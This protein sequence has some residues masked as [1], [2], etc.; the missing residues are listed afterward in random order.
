MHFAIDPP[1]IN[2]SL[3][4]RF[5]CESFKQT[6]TVKSKSVAKREIIYNL[7]KI[8]IFT[9]NREYLVYYT[10]QRTRKKKSWVVHIIRIYINKFCWLHSLT[11]WASS[12]CE[13]GQKATTLHL[14]QGG[15]ERTLCPPNLLLYHPQDSYNSINEPF[16]KCHSTIYGPWPPRQQVCG[17]P[18]HHQSERT[19]QN[20]IL[21]NQI[22]SRH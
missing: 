11:Q 8:L 2:K 3:P 4:Q 22:Y 19:L 10:S 18:Q 13:I 1:N 5:P 21:H 12:V 15:F 16:S 9:E 6:Q 7:K 20:L 17:I 14:L